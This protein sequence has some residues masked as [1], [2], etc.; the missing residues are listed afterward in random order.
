MGII[1]IG[2]GLYFSFNN[3]KEM[4]PGPFEKEYESGGVIA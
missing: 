1:F 3:E 4:L 2:V